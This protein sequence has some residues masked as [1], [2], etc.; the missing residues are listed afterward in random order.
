MISQSHGVALLGQWLWVEM[1]RT[2]I[3]TKVQTGVRVVE[4]EV[5][6]SGTAGKR[7]VPE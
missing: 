7:V 3:K 5:G 1:G 4:T 2:G 6:G